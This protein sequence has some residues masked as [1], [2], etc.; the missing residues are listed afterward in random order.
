MQRGQRECTLPD[1]HFYG[2][3]DKYN[4]SKAHYYT[5]EVMVEGKCIVCCLNFLKFLLLIPWDGVWFCLFASTVLSSSIFDFLNTLLYPTNRDMNSYFHGKLMP[6]NIVFSNIEGPQRW[7][8]MFKLKIQPAY[9][10]HYGQ[11]CSK[12]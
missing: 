5:E 12:T 4:F 11:H 7:F 6:M 1:F 8:C 2:G 9:T 10:L 3:N